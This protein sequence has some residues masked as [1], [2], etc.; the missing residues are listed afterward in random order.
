MICAWKR[1]LK[2][3]QPKRKGQRF[4]KEQCATSARVDAH[5]ARVRDAKRAVVSDA[6]IPM[7]ACYEECS[8][9][10]DEFLALPV[11]NA[12]GVKRLYC[13]S[14]SCREKARAMRY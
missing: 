1:C 8:F 11:L 6:G 9:C 4:C 7:I 5:R 12:G 3:F 10:G 13:K 2:A 14:S